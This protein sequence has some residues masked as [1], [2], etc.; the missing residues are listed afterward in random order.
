[1]GRPPG[2]PGVCAGSPARA[3]AGART[4]AYTAVG[5][6]LEDHITKTGP[7]ESKTSTKEAEILKLW[8]TDMNR[9]ARCYHEHRG[10]YVHPRPSP[11][12]RLLRVGAAESAGL[13]RRARARPGEAC[14]AHRWRPG[15]P[16]RGIDPRT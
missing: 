14:G 11:A 2:R 12:D 7:L 6:R 5:G 13:S 16:C 8:K 15:I 10:H 3:P 1:M 4:T 9:A